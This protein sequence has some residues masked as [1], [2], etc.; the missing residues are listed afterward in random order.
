MTACGSG[1]S[2]EK[3][4]PPPTVVESQEVE[5]AIVAAQKRATP[6]L[7]VRD[8]SCPA[9]IVVSEG[10]TFQCT[11]AVEGVIVP[12]EVTLTGARTTL[13][14]N[15]APAKAILL[16]P[17]LVTALQYNTPGS[18]IDCGP[19]RVRVLDVGAVFECTVTDAANKAQRVT[20]KV[21]DVEGNVSQVSPPP[22][23]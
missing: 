19:D 9:R 16:I 12:Y 10:A 15:I 5:N 18:H 11:V 1:K 8:P 14:Y 3:P 13:R 21:N 6:D 20:L 2:A 22:T 4:S 23:T 7:D 17:K